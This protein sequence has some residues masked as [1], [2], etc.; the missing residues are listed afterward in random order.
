MSIEQKQFHT[1]ARL[2]MWRSHADF[3][4]RLLL[5]TRY[6][7]LRTPCS[8]RTRSNSTPSSFDKRSSFLRWGW[9]TLSSRPKTKR[10]LQR[11][12][13]YVLTAALDAFLKSS[14]AEL[15]QCSE[16]VP[17]LYLPSFLPLDRNSNKETLQH[18]RIL[19]KD[20]SILH[21]PVLSHKLPAATFVFAPSFRL[22]VAP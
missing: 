3:T 12:V 10:G 17:N 21:A 1:V 7:I 2:A 13:G 16:Y 5:R 18:L 19:P 15:P 9:S 11:L 14:R 4:A 20:P 6:C 8:T 22:R